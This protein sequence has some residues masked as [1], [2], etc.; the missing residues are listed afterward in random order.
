M[1]SAAGAASPRRCNDL[2]HWR[3]KVQLLQLGVSC[4]ETSSFIAFTSEKLTLPRGEGQG[5]LLCMYVC[6][7]DNHDHMTIT[8]LFWM[9]T[10]EVEEYDKEDQLC[11]GR[12]PGF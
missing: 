7:Y 4:C 6:V 10:E 2:C 9:A 1:C 3:H 8:V 12:K 11:R 5:S